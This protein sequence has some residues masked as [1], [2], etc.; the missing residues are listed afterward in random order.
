MARRS[1]PHRQLDLPRL[2]KNGQHRGGPRKGAGRPRKLTSDG[3]KRMPHVRRPTI[4]PSEPV[5]VTIRTIE[6]VSELRGFDAYGAVRKA[7]V[8]T[9]G[10]SGFRIVH[11]SIQGNHVHLMIEA[12]NRRE[13]SCGMRG[14]Q[15]SAAKHLNAAIS[16]RRH[17]RRRRRGKVFTDRYHATIIR[18][19]SH[20]RRELVYVLNN[21]RK[22]GESQ[23]V[24][25]RGWCIDPLSSA[26]S[27]DGWKDVDIKRL[28]PPPEL[29][30]YLPLPVWEPRSWLLREGWR[31]YGLIRSNEVPKSNWKPS[32]TPTSPR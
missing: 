20:A 3:R 18:T 28:R 27:F 6:D 4:K 24:R 12:D 31:R 8:S 25:A 9:L 10:R 16:K 11:I 1:K 14:F 23:L 5:Q 13:L 2:D 26:P 32:K 7:M 21:W 15:I 19:P 22:H 17:L 29:E 30:P